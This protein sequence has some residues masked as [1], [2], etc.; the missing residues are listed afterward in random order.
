MTSSSESD[1]PS[2]DE[3]SIPS[4]YS[5]ASALFSKPVE[6]SDL[7]PSNFSS[8]ID[9][10]G[11][12][13]S[14]DSKK[15]LLSLSKNLRDLLRDV[16]KQN[17]NIHKT[18]LGSGKTDPNDLDWAFVAGKIA[19]AQHLVA[20]MAHERGSDEF[21][22]AIRDP[23]NTACF[24]FLSKN[25]LT[26]QE[27]A[28]LLNQDD[29]E[30]FE[31]I[32]ELISLNII[33]CRFKNKL[34]YLSLYPTVAHYMKA[35]NYIVEFQKRVE[36]WLNLCFGETIAK[37]QDRRNQRFLEES[38][39]LVQACG[40]TAEDAHQLVDY[41]YGRPAGEKAQEVGGVLLTLAGL[42]S[43]QG[44]D[45]NDSGEKELARVWTKVDKIRIKEAAKPSSSPLPGDTNASMSPE[46]AM[47]ALAEQAQALKLGYD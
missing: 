26:I 27:L 6:F 47:Q 14:V 20:E 45:M 4:F 25:E 3:T 22:R 9:E 18:V 19:F 38:L 16:L 37:D 23:S 8:L 34:T 28:R 17:P 7:S 29:E 31:R 1:A 2:I 24:E 44:L 40:C 41:V 42:C 5:L 35:P 13:S 39:E 12:A 33:R 30:V 10:I 36:Q 46:E 21:L 11:T 43:A 15:H 32:N